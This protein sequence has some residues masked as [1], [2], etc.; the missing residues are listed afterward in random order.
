VLGELALAPKPGTRGQDTAADVG[1]QLAA[2]V[3][4][5]GVLA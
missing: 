4:R 1:Q 3:L 2:Q 5:H